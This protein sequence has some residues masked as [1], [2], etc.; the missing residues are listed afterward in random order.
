MMKE[1]DHP[2]DQVRLGLDH[3]AEEADG[4]M[5]HAD[6][7]WCPAAFGLAFIPHAVFEG[8]RGANWLGSVPP[9]YIGLIAPFE[10]SYYRPLLDIR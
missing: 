4:V 3:F 9:A 5:V 8:T 1:G 10:V 6:Q 7:W 2:G